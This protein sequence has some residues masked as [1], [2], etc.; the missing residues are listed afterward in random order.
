MREEYDLKKL[1]VKRHGLLPGLQTEKD[2]PAKVRITIALDQD[3]VEYF[4]QSADRAGSLPY[5]TQ[6]NQALRKAIETSRRDDVDTLK[7]ELLKDTDFIRAVAH[8]IG[9][10]RHQ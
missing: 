2:K 7:L 8:Q 4:K 6:I 9:V 1:K 3:V 10:A 5:Q